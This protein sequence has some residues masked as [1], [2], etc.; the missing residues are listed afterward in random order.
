M[1]AIFGYSGFVGS[2]LLTQ[3][4]FEY[5]YNSKNIESA[6]NKTFDKIFLS[7]IPAQ[8]WYAN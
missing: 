1:S 4:R 2:T 7:C 6:Q 3:Y 8:K 5:F